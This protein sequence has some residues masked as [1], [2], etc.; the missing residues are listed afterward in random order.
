MPPYLLG[1]ALFFFTMGIFLHYVSDAQK[2]YTLQLK[3]GLIQEG[4]FGR[5][6]NPNYL[7]EILIYIAFAIMSLH[8]LPFLVLAGWISGFF[9]RSMLMIDAGLGKK[10]C[11]DPGHSLPRGTMSLTSAT[12]RPHPIAEQMIPV[13]RQEGGGRVEKAMLSPPF[14]WRGCKKAQHIFLI[15]LNRHLRL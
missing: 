8:W 15:C 13:E 12:Q 5:I 6:R 1:L 14:T 10:A 3:K 9:V 4:L 11:C 7:G 2:F